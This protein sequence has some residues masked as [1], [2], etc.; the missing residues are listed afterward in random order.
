M[1]YVHITTTTRAARLVV[2]ALAITFALSGC[3]GGSSGT[4]SSAHISPHAMLAR[5][6]GAW[7]AAGFVS[8]SGKE[9]LG[10]ERLRGKRRVLVVLFSNGRCGVAAESTEGPGLGAS[11]V[12]VQVRRGFELV[13]EQ[14]PH[15]GGSQSEFSANEQLEKTVE[16]QVATEANAEVAS[17]GKLVDGSGSIVEIVGSPK[18]CDESTGNSTDPGSGSGTVSEGTSTETTTSTG[19]E[20]KA[21]SCSDPENREIKELAVSGA[22]CSTAQSVTSGVMSSSKCLPNDQSTTAGSCEIKNYDC[23][24][25]AVKAEENEVTCSRDGIVVRIHEGP[26]VEG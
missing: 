14:V 23:H 8:D 25:Q 15:C 1:R 19:S 11:L 22:P 26:P 2:F 18:G 5:C 3:G 6:V 21:S 17:G 9:I 12:W 16:A 10:V 20:A 13:A 7:N 24:S 4:G